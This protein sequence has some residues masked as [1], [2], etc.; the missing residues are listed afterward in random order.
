MDVVIERA[1]DFYKQFG[2]IPL[3]S[4]PLKLFIPVDSIRQLVE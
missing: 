3:P 1:A 2:Y 4:N